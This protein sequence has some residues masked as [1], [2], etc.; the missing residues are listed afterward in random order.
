MHKG[1]DCKV[2]YQMKVLIYWC[3]DVS[4]KNTTVFNLRGQ[5]SKL[6][7]VCIMDCYVAMKNYIFEKYLKTWYYDH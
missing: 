4:N 6:N 7:Q 2:T 1:K 3:I 5:V